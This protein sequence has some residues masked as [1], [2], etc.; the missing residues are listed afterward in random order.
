MPIEDVLVL[1]VD[2]GRVTVAGT[3]LRPFC[4]PFSFV[5]CL[6]CRSSRVGAA[7]Y[8]PVCCRP[9]L[10]AA[11]GEAVTLQHALLQPLPGQVQ[12]AP[13]KSN[14]RIIYLI[15]VQHW[16]RL[17]DAVYAMLDAYSGSEAVNRPVAGS[18]FLSAAA[19]AFCAG[20][21]DMWRILRVFYVRNG[22]LREAHEAGDV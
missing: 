6:F 14:R 9:H 15:S 3:L 2:D 1:D 8:R 22:E 5:F 17:A 11:A 4:Y 21:C 7:L 13:Q 16:N 20:Y 18:G 10:T 19:D 12:P